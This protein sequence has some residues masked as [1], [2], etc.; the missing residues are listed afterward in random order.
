MTVS[1]MQIGFMPERETFD[2]VFMLRRLQEFCA[3]GKVVYVFYGLV[4]NF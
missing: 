1:G 2:S 3:K 4:Q